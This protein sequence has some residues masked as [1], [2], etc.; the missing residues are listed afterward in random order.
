MAQNYQ[1]CTTAPQTD[2]TLTSSDSAAKAVEENPRNGS[3]TIPVGIDLGPMV[4]PTDAPS[5]AM[6]MG[7][8]WAPGRQLKISFLSGSDWQKSKVKQYAP[9]WCKYANLSMTF[10][11]NGPCDIL[12]DFNPTL[13]SWSFY[14]TDSGYFINQRKA[15]MNLG[16][17]NE[18]QKEENLRQVILH[19]FG[20]ALGAI[21]EHESPFANIPWNKERVYKDLGGPP[22]NWDHAKV[23]SNMF[24]LYTLDKV[25]A[26]AFDLN[27]IMLYHY[28]AEWTTNGKATP[29]NTDLS[30]GDKSYIRFVY[31]P[32]SLDAGQFNTMEVRPST[33]PQEK[34][35]KT[36]LLWKKYDH[37]PRIPFGLTSLD[38]S[39]DKNI[40]VI[41]GAADIAQDKFT[42]SLNSW[43][44]T[45]LYGA[46]LT[47][48]EAGP[49]FDYLLTGTF[50][51]TE[52]SKWQDHKSQVSKRINFQ[53]P[54]DG[55]PPKVL[56]WLTT[57][58]MS[59]DR[60]FR[61]KTFATD[62]D[63][64]GFTAH[65]E[66]WDDSILYQAGITWL[67][68]P[69]NHPNVA[70]GSFGTDDIR[71]ADKPQLENSATIKF[72]AGG[73]KFDKTPKLA[74]ALT[75]FDYDHSKNLRLR[76][77]T[78]AVTKEAMTWH[79][80]AWGDSRMFRG[81]ASYFAWA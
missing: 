62:I 54:F 77:S 13:G 7:K 51:T 4:P 34:T 37:P 20:H 10:V 44:D 70:S 31:P 2:D 79:L 76:L 26:T 74:M 18:N 32:A 6:Y 55:Q 75:G 57:M 24:T 53:H 52:V 3:L 49:G 38:V 11:D 73:G 48:L 9:I 36:K 33:K 1:V 81:S 25:E 63:A 16:W 43:G 80:Q 67:A 78:S 47:Y 58:D 71:H 45:V 14:G 30:E 46:S 15:S 19:E 12:I 72:A 66:T 39:N 68:Y 22:N 5:L 28:A 50:H 61:I 21:H 69:G 42:A 29:F 60:N 41:A 56:C 64:K 17:I 59:K 35:T 8:F 27:S 40:R 65:I 23:D